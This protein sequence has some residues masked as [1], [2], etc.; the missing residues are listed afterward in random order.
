MTFI[1]QIITLVVYFVI[2]LF[3]FLERINVKKKDLEICFLKLQ[4]LKIK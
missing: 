1:G 3:L 2:V 4:G